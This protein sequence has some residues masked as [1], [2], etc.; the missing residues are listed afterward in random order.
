MA[1]CHRNFVNCK[2][3][4]SRFHTDNHLIDVWEYANV[5]INVFLNENFKFQ[6]NFSYKVSRKTFWLQLEETNINSQSAHT[7]KNRTSRICYWCLVLCFT[8]NQMG[9]LVRAKQL[10]ETFL[11]SKGNPMIHIPNV[12]Q[13]LFSFRIT[14]LKTLEWHI[15]TL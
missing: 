10:F 2:Y 15:L 9:C 13:G 1:A 3:N 12:C 8:C 4:F 14:N 7:I 6:I 11:T 5:E